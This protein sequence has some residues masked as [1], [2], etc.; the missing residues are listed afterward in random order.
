VGMLFTARLA[1]AVD[2]RSRLPAIASG[3]QRH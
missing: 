2:D 3:I 1:I